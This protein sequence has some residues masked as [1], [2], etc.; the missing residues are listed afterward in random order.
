MKVR[1][2]DIFII[3]EGLVLSSTHKLPQT[4]FYHILKTI[5]IIFFLKKDV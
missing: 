3:V 4:W 2:N 1:F 5:F